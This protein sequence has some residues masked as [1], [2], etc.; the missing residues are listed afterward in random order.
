MRAL[1]NILILI[2]FTFQSSN[3]QYCKIKTEN[4]ASFYETSFTE[5]EKYCVD[6]NTTLK[7]YW[8]G[9]ILNGYCNGEGTITCRSKTTNNTIY[10]EIVTFKDGIRNG[11]FVKRLFDNNYIYESRGKIVNGTTNGLVSNTISTKRGIKMAQ[12]FFLISYGDFESGQTINYSVFG[13][14]T[15]TYIG[16]YYEGDQ[17]LIGSCFVDNV[18]YQKGEFTFSIGLSLLRNYTNLLTLTKGTVYFD[19]GLSLYS[20]QFSLFGMPSK[21]G[22][23]NYPNGDYITSCSFDWKNFDISGQ[24]EYH[25]ANGSYYIGEFSKSKITQKGTFYDG[26]GKN[27][28]GSFPS[29]SKAKNGDD[30]LLGIAT[31]GL[32]AWG[33]SELQPISQTKTTPTETKKDFSGSYSAFTN[34]SNTSSSSS[35]SSSSNTKTAEKPKCSACG[36]RGVCLECNG[37]GTQLC[38]NCDGKGTEKVPDDSRNGTFN[39]YTKDAPCSKCSGSGIKKCTSCSGKGTCYRCYGKGTYY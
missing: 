35:S 30:L 7:F 34:T 22:T 9:E 26:K 19:N 33:I 10:T 18:L 13:N 21:C 16:K 6:Q 20:D 25:W 17:K 39:W 38:K 36:G 2:G 23:L 24:G 27:N 15:Y 5:N 28:Y 8:S 4:N 3:A 12:T 11:E 32:I 29:Y 1:L 31:V 37:R 14:S